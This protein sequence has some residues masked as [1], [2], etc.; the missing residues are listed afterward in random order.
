MNLRNAILTI[1][2]LVLLVDFLSADTRAQGT[3]DLRIVM[4]GYL[5][6]YYRVPDVQPTDFLQDC[7]LGANADDPW[8]K[9][10]PAALD[11]HKK[12]GVPFVPDASTIFVGM[13]DNLGVELYSRTYG[14]ADGAR[15]PEHLHPKLRNPGVPWQPN[16]DG[17]IGD[18]VGC[19]LSMADY[20]AIVPG[21]EDLY[22]GPERLRR[23]AQR[24]ASV[25]EQPG[26]PLHP[27]PML[28]ANLI[29]Q[30]TYWEDPT[31]IPDS[32]KE[33]NFTPGLPAGL[34][35]VEVDDH[36]KV[37]PFLR[38]ITLRV[39][40][41]ANQEQQKLYLCSADPANNADNLIPGKMRVIDPSVCP[42]LKNPIR[43]PNK[44]SGKEPVDPTYDVTYDLPTQLLANT[45]YGFCL[46]P[47][48][49]ETKPRC[50][51]F[52]VT[53]PFFLS[54]ACLANGTGTTEACK[55]YQK[56][57][58]FKKLS[59]SRQVVI[60]GVVDPSLVSLVGRD[61]LSWKNRDGKL[62]TEVAALDPLPA[63]Q[64]A[65]QLFEEDEK[66]D[67]DKS[68]LRWVLLAQM[69]RAKAEELAAHLAANTT[70]DLH[71][72]AVIAAAADRTHATSPR[73]IALDPE[74]MGF[75]STNP[76][77]CPAVSFRPVVV[78]PEWGF[79]PDRKPIN[80][81]RDLTL[82]DYL[83]GYSHAKREATLT[84]DRF[85]IHNGD[86]TSPG[87]VRKNLNHCASEFLAPANEA[88][89]KVDG[90]AC[91]T[92][93]GAGAVKTGETDPFAT[94]T[95]RILRE[96][97]NAD[98]AMM[99]KRD[100]Y[101]G[102][103][104]RPHDPVGGNVAQVL[105]KGDVLRV[106]TATGD[107]LKKILAESK[108]FDRADLQATQEV[109]EVGRG[110]VFY[111]LEPTEDDNYLINGALLDKDRLYTI[112]T[113]NHIA[114]GDTGYPELN[115]PSL[116]DKRLSNSPSLS[117]TS[118]PLKG[119]E[120]EGRQI[121]ELVCLRLSLAE[122]VTLKDES[123]LFATTHEEIPQVKA[124]LGAK[125]K[126]W[127]FNSL[128]QPLFSKADDPASPELKAQNRPIW[129]FSLLQASLSFQESINNVSEKERALLFTGF[130]A[131]GINGANSH[132]WQISKKAEL[133]RS[134][135]WL[136]EY[137][138]NQL[139]YSSQVNEQ[140]A[141]ALPSVSRDKNRDQF[142]AGF[143]YHPFTACHH[144]LPCPAPRKEY[145]KYGFVFEPFRFDS[146]LAQE[147]LIIGPKT[148]QEKVNLGRS[149]GLLA[150]TGLRIENAKS[151]YEAGYEAGWE[152]G[153]LVTFLA[154]N[155]SCPPLPNQSP[156][157]CLTNLT[158]PVNVDQV[159]E[160]RH[161]RGFYIDYAWTTPLPFHNWQNI[162]QAQGEWFP[163]GPPNDN[164]SDTRK[165]FDI[166]EK[167]SIPIVSSLSIQPGG[168]YFFYRNKFGID[169]LARWTPSATLSWSFDRYSGGKWGKSLSYSPNATEAA[170][171]SK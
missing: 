72:D 61:N 157:G 139:D 41:S 42:L 98:F 18:N 120:A 51:R 39:K 102:T 121:S 95:L 36:G 12:N 66:K 127:W 53:R 24:L 164:S 104:R 94:A 7:L 56:P 22:F 70:A 62:R 48:P 55:D 69:S 145:P 92:L 115:D 64:Q 67:L 168:E 148:N 154:G 152:R 1:L 138:R 15:I 25:R 63:L 99:Q 122:C 169:H 82:K 29:Q 141:P 128:N 17:R 65:V 158:P 123:S 16:D 30:T 44:D 135:K 31:K 162:V 117:K 45:N 86:Q 171:G 23:I 110:L 118:L 100:F 140:I 163:F 35:I 143:F 68:K 8:A 111:G 129:R 49:P 6:G 58:V 33:L 57:Y 84:A 153:A 85:D 9:A 103:F 73:T 81:L 119:Q 160:T 83:D 156:E 4:T 96:A 165:L 133:V 101:W 91:E 159:R 27:V 134:G 161:R 144:F 74:S 146:P 90:R 89:K 77:L 54:S 78:V 93:G 147:E 13:G 125:M 126:S 3:P 28:A 108:Q 151:H 40:V 112:A 106:I 116:A 124:D 166:T 79:D 97:T 5:L 14:A 21:K 11:L 142:D 46:N 130:S 2:G 149:Q 20:T 150:R 10:S 52:T 26:S 137:V 114:V 80:P 38:K 32:Q 155:T 109:E 131:P 50:I 113:S 105:W 87:E 60:F 59:P 34:E 107:T 75:D 88:R 43:S 19:F 37:L 170:G 71:F 136:D 167:L 132:K 47:S 76:S